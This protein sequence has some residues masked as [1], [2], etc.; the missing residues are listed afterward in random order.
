MTSLPT[1]AR[2]R[3]LKGALETAVR[4]T[5]ELALNQTLTGLAA[6]EPERWNFL[7]DSL[8]AGME[9]CEQGSI[10]QILTALDGTLQD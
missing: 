4:V 9:P 8:V 3:E 7:L 2:L 6:R 5:K 10:V 1:L